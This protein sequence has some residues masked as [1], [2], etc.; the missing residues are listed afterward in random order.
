MIDSKELLILL[1]KF[2]KGDRNAFQIVYESTHRILYQT[3][4]LLVCSKEVAEDLLQDAYIRILEHPWLHEKK[5]NVLAFFITVAKNLAFN[6]LKKH[7]HEETIKEEQEPYYFYSYDKKEDTPLLQM[8]TSVLKK[9]ELL[10][11][12]LYVIEEWTHKEIAKLLHRP[13][14]TITYKYQ[15]ALKKLKERLEKENERFLAK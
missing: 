9:D 12:Y 8:M 4:Y 11:V 13:L 2:Q 3:I 15:V 14:G 1:Q 5:G 7:R 6:Y 10:I